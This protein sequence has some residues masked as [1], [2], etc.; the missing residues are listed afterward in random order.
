MLPPCLASFACRASADPPGSSQLRPAPWTCSTV[1]SL[2]L[3]LWGVEEAPQAISAQVHNAVS[4]PSEPWPK[5]KSQMRTVTLRDC[6]RARLGS[7]ASCWKLSVPGK[8]S[9]ALHTLPGSPVP[10]SRCGG[11]RAVQMV[12]EA[13]RVWL[14]GSLPRGTELWA[15]FVSGL[16]AFSP[17]GALPAG[18]PVLVRPNQGYSLG[19][20]R[21]LVGVR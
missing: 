19:T 15:G 18:V 20:R 6:S 21:G 5:Y 14:G 9:P 12:L 2:C 3:G 17:R 7:S 4:G 13:G 11:G 10:S 16:F 1:P 8:N